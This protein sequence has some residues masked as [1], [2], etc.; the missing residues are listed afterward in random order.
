MTYW[1][2]CL[3]NN[4]ENIKLLR[5]QCKTECVAYLLYHFIAEARLLRVQ[6]LS[7]LLNCIISQIEY[8]KHRISDHSDNTADIVVYTLML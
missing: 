8:Y 4:T 3:A 6:Y 2:G 1:K 5:H 7:K